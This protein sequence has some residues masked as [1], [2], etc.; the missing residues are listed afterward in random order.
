[1]NSVMA[2]LTVGNAVLGLWVLLVF[3]V[4]ILAGSSRTPVAPAAMC[5]Q[6][7]VMGAFE[8]L[9]LLLILIASVNERTFVMLPIVFITFEIAGVVGIVTAIIGWIRPRP[10]APAM[11]PMQF[12]M[13]ELLAACAG[14]GLLMAAGLQLFRPRWEED[15]LGMLV[16]IVVSQIVAFLVSSDVARWTRARAAVFVAN[17]LLCVFPPTIFLVLVA[18]KGWRGNLAAHLRK[19]AEAAARAPGGAP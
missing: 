5:A 15:R 12:R 14:T 11:P 16:Y 10:A 6:A 1:M 17:A 19:Q 8:A 2:L 7:L 18:W 3:G 9:M 4:R 13:A